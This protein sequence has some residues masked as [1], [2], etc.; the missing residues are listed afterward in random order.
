MK[1]ASPG[2]PIENRQHSAIQRNRL[3]AYS[4]YTEIM[5]PPRIPVLSNP[6][7]IVGT[8]GSIRPS[9]F[10]TFPSEVALQ[11]IVE[12]L[13]PVEDDSLIAMLEPAWRQITELSCWLLIRMHSSICPRD[14]SKLWSLPLTIA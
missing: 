1:E 10:L 2:S 4:M 5:A 9:V 12:C 3:A 14:N 8:D 11:A 13:R 7:V 6:R